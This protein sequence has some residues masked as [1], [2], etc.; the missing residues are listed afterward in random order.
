MKEKTITR[1]T[2]H[3]SFYTKDGKELV[4]I[5]REDLEKLMNII[6]NIKS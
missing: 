4:V 2:I 6:Q 3:Y 5:T 1:P